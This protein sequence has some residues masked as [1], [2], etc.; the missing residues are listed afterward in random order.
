MDQRDQDRR[1]L[2]AR[3]LANVNELVKPSLE[4]LKKC[5]LTKEAAAHVSIL[6]ATLGEIVSPFTQ[7]L[8]ETCSNLTSTEIQVVNLIKQ[9]MRSK[10]IADLM[11]L[12]KGTIDFY[13]KT[14]RRKLGISNKKT[15]LRA[16][17]LSKS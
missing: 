7:H 6:E 12:S 17:L 5:S 3:I 13:R 15:N 4:K 1:N 11:K 9:G 14:V 16:H 2:E 10:E 8:A